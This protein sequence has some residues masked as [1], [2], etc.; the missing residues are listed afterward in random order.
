M[1]MQIRLMIVVLFMSILSTGCGNPARTPTSTPSPTQTPPPTA[2]SVPTITPTITPALT[3]SGGGVIAYVS[4]ESNDWQIYV[5][6]ADGSGLRKVT[7]GVRGGYEPNWSLDGT[8]IIFQYGGLWIADIAS[9][10][11]SQIPLSVK[12]NN[13]PN[14][15]LVK[16]AWSPNGE[17][18]A[19]LNESGTRGDIYLIRPDGTDL[20]RLTDS[21]DISRDGNLVWSPDGKQLAYSAYSD[22]NI[23]I[24]IMDVESALQGATASR[25]LTDS[26][27]RTWNLVTSWSS[28]GSRLA[29]SSDRDGNTEI[30]LMNLDG[31]NVVRLTNNP[32]SDAQPA[33]S[34]DGKQ[35]AFSSD[36]DGNVEIYV[37]DVEEALQSADDA[38]VRRLTDRPG[39]DM[40]PVW[41]PEP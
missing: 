13:L 1:S 36:R 11:I 33:W 19:F 2:T 14:E 34:P 5:M 18:I 10:E 35:I 21:N 6:N 27:T 4:L 31:S 32:A 41:K 3:G 38:T 28:D 17:W 23:E 24:Y 7:I 22:G 16:P 29:F 30:Y 15:Y 39:D 12:G 9:G 20:R 8:K 40:G 37:L 25:Q 26:P